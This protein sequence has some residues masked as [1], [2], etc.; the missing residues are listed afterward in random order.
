MQN[1]SASSVKISG[2]PRWA[3]ERLDSWKE[4]ASFFRR[5]VRTVQ[6]WEKGEGLPVRRQH[7]K[8][9]GTIYAYRQELEAW[10][11]ARSTMSAFCREAPKHGCHQNGSTAQGQRSKVKTHLVSKA[12]DEREGPRIL[13][14]PFAVINS[15]LDHR[16]RRQI[17]AK[18]SEGLREELLVEL[19][20]LHWHPIIPPALAHSDAEPAT[21]TQTPSKLKDICGEYKAEV[22]LRGSIRYSTNQ[23]RV[24]VQV[25]R[26]LD[27]LCLW[28]D[29]FDTSLENILGAQADLAGRIGRSL[30]EQLL[31][32]RYAAQLREA[33]PNQELAAHA[34][35]IGFHHWQQRGPVAL[36]KALSYFKDAIEL[37]S[38]CA[39][40]Y[41]G[42]ADTYVSLSYN[43]LMAARQAA[44]RAAE[45]VNTA[46]KLDGQSIKVRNAYLNLLINCSWDWKTAERKCQ[47][48]TESGNMDARTVQLYSSLMNCTGRHEDAVTLA[49]HSYRR[50]P[51]CDFVNG[52][53]SLAYF[54]AGDYCNATSFVR[55]TTELQPQYLLGYALLGR[56]EAERGNWNDAISALARGLDVSKGSPFFKALLAYSYAGKGDERTARILLREIEVESH[57]ACFPAYDVAAVHTIL[58]QQEDSLLNIHKAYRMRD[59]KAIFVKHDPRF[60]TLHNLTGFQQVASAVSSGAQAQHA[61]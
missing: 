46:L 39:E 7:H 18:F 5:D 40:A 25:I 34:C 16:P 14:C 36:L 15:P 33:T 55:R 12:P 19:L 38:Q 32:G 30:P 4:V 61:V 13:V 22:L 59:I 1:S 42:L 41:A 31:R 35:S 28:S 48:A 20:R 44:A 43:H 17:V 8:K 58:G 54:Y 6:L 11:E 2:L 57:D 47:E 49:L 23:L 24:S 26:A 29:R 52:Q 27:S 51:H 60:V 10:W 45:A 21:P 50:E 56:A 37:D 53:V 3:P 9:L